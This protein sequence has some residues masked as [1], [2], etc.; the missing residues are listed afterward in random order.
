M[1][2][3]TPAALAQAIVGHRQPG[4]TLLVGITGS[5]AVGKTTL[6]AELA[7]ALPGTVELVGTDGF[8]RRNAD[9]DAAGLAMR[10][11]FPETYDREGLAATLAALRQGPAL[12]P[13]YSHALYD[14]DPALARSV[15]GDVVLVEGLGLAPTDAPPHVHEGLDLLIYIDADPADIEAWYVA[16]FIGLWAAAD[17]D[18]ASFYRRFR[19]LDEA[20]A[21]DFARH[22]WATINKPNLDQ[23]ISRAWD[24]ADIVVKKALDHSLYLV[25]SRK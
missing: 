15:A 20:G 13:G 5:V 8:L 11:G 24:V 25:T 23:H 18:P 2:P 14:V 16:R 21:R 7:A 1:Q 3:I 12:V 9:L 17:D 19:D 6:A 4:R 22:I 10:K